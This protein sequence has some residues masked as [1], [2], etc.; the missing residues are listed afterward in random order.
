MK[1]GQAS[2][3]AKLIAA[4]TL[5]QG[6]DAATRTQVPPG[7]AALCRAFLG[8]TALDCALCAG[9]QHR[10]LRP[11]WRALE[12][13]TLPGMVSH[14]AQR[15]AWI[16][17]RCRRALAD[18]TRRVIVVGAGFDT[19]ALRLAHEFDAV[20]WLEIDHPATQGAKLRGLERHRWPVPATLR[21]MAADLDH[22]RVWPERAGSS[23]NDTLVICE[24]LLMYLAPERVHSLLQRELRSVAPRGLRVI[25][26][27]MQ[28]G[29]FQPGSRLVDAWLRWRGEPF[30]WTAEP[31]TIASWLQTTGYALV[32]QRCSPL[33]GTG[34][35]GEHL[36]DSRAV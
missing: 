30:R 34:M 19:L 21:F 33:Q 24:G 3:T 18:G 8:D 25:F 16:E 13:A 28:R 5:L 29:G 15:K 9:A 10:A 20:Q 1:R 27:H 36:V 31:A 14:F 7:A 32:E 4:S 17:A 2:A 26:S 12:R 35:R 22:D 11:L 6:S 23:D